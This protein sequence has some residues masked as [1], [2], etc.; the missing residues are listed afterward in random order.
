MTETRPG[1]MARIVVGVALLLPVFLYFMLTNIAPGLDRSIAIPTPHFFIVSAAALF[2]LA[3][4]VLVGVASV[5]S[6]EPRT[7]FIA[8]GFM[9]IAGIFSV[10]GLTTPGAN[11][12]VKEMHHSLVISARLSLFVGS[13]FFVLSAFKIPRRFDRLISRHH[14]TLMIA[15]VAVIALYIGANLAKPNILDFIPTGT[16]PRQVQSTASRVD[17]ETYSNLGYSTYTP[18]AA[19]QAAPTLVYS[20]AEEIGRGLGY[21]MAIAGLACFLIAAW[22]YYATYALTRTPAAGAL[23]AGLILLAEAQ[24]IM[25]LGTTWNLSWW[26]YHGAILLGFVIPVAAIGIAHHRGRSLSQIVDGFFVRDAFSKVERSFPDAINALI[27][28]IEKKDPYLRGHMRRVGELT[29]QIAEEMHLP[30]S[31]ARAASHAALLH[32]LGK[33]GIPEFILHK[34]EQLTD[35]EFEVMK[36]HPERGYDMVMQSPTLHAAAPAIRWHHERLDGSGYPDRID[37]SVIPI[38]ARIVAVADVWDALTSDR[39]Y[40]K[41]LS[42]AKAREIMASEAGTKLDASCVTALMNVLDREERE[43]PIPISQRSASRLGDRPLPSFLAS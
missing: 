12:P 5:Q 4:G 39:V 20:R 10:H 6:K 32:D 19:P 36:I 23:T 40:R 9:F 3:M 27:D 25:T 16:T 2:A 15:T 41:A 37:D 8:A 42:P 33:L 7:F 29:V 24:L 31:V 18:S 30:D 21:G 28:V 14:S 26:L 34:T 38:E 43:A 35:A 1:S 17:S 22:R 13:L 11:M